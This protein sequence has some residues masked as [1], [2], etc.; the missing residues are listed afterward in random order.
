[1]MELTQKHS[2]LLDTPKPLSYIETRIPLG[3]LN[4]VVQEPCSQL[5]KCNQHSNFT[6]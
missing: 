3:L 4:Q 6:E 2:V 1:M 5:K